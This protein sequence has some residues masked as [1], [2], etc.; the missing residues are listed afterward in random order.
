[1]AQKLTQQD[2]SHFVQAG[3]FRLHYNE[4]GSGQPLIFLHGSGPG[5]TS[6]SNFVQNFAF[7]AEHYHVYLVDQPGYGES[8]PVLV[9][10]DT[11]RQ[12]INSDAVKDFMDALGIKKA[13]FVGN[14]MGGSTVLSF[15]VDYPELVDKIILMGSGGAGGFVFSPMPTEGLKLR[16]ISFRKPSIQSVGDFIEVMVYDA[17][18]L[19][20]ELLQQRYDAMMV[21]ED[22]IANFNNSNA[23]QRNLAPDL[24]TIKAQTLLIHGRD[25]RVVPLESSLRLLSAIPNSQ[26]HI[27]S[28]CGHWSQYERADEFNRL[29]L[30]FLLH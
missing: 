19:T 15:T 13:N 24:P 17:S 18:F 14:S 4:A 11:T 7:F 5:A 23:K 10:D 8:D 29:V 6:W 27:F 21:N 3:N 16:D 22:H 1:M 30:D 9:G 26:L 20:D 2:T 25:D 28:K 12:K